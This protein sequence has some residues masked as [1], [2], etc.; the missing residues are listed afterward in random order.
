MKVMKFIYFKNN[1]PKR[2][3]KYGLEIIKTR[4]NFVGVNTHLANKIV[5]HALNNNLN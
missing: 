5:N 1:D 4:K 2:K 3:L